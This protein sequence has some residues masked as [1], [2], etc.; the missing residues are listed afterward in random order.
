MV[1]ALIYQQAQKELNGG[2]FNPTVTSTEISKML[3]MEEIMKVPWGSFNQ[4]QAFKRHELA[5]GRVI[6]K[7][8]GGSVAYMPAVSK[9]MREEIMKRTLGFDEGEETNIKR[10][11]DEGE[12][13]I[14]CMSKDIEERP[15]LVGLFRRFV[16]ASGNVVDN[17]HPF[18]NHSRVEK[19]LAEQPL[20]R[21]FVNIIAGDAQRILD[22]PEYTG[23]SSMNDQYKGLGKM[24]LI[25]IYYDGEEVYGSCPDGTMRPLKELPIDE[26]HKAWIWDGLIDMVTR[27]MEYPN[28]YRLGGNGED[29]STVPLCDGRMS[30]ENRGSC[31]EFFDAMENGVGIK[32]VERVIEEA[33][34]QGGSTTFKVVDTLGRIHY[35][36]SSCKK[37]S[38][39]CK[40]RSGK[41][42]EQKEENGRINET[43]L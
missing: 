8:F 36:C 19:F 27:P 37:S 5:D 7:G 16:E 29:T 6:I 14:F 28:G 26:C 35:L 17:E 38:E 13:E 3:D 15:D 21:N 24:Y 12:G 11:Q 30:E 33:K 1:E 31:S 23:W 22:T 43:P 34:S 25:E 32:S 4:V 40:C 18:R 42:E 2:S 39:D 41:K 20:R 9:S 10:W